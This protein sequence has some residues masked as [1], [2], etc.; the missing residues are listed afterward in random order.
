M[1]F[2]L[3]PLIIAL[4]VLAYALMGWLVVLI[5]GWFGPQLAVWQGVVIAVVVSRLTGGTAQ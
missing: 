2:L 4:V 3:I 1:K 5:V